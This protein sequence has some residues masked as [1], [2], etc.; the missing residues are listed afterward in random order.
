MVCEIIVTKAMPAMYVLGITLHLKSV[1]T[2]AKGKNSDGEIEKLL[3]RK[4]DE[5]EALRKI[6][7]KLNLKNKNDMKKK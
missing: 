7:S 3:K 1:K 5:A 2:M 4:K 6:L